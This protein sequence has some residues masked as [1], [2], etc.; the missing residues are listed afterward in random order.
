M[1]D[2][3]LDSFYITSTKHGSDKTPTW[4]LRSFD[5]KLNQVVWV[6][7]MKKAREFHTK[8]EALEFAK[9]INREYT[10]EEVEDWIF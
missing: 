10:I 2:L 1:H 5:E 4:Y 9:T 8:S 3:C 7:E 6:A